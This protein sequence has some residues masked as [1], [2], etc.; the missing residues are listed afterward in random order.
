MQLQKSDIVRHRLVQ[1]AHDLGSRL[2]D[3]FMT[4]AF[5]ALSVIPTLKLTDMGLVDVEKFE[6]TSLFV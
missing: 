5:M 2:H 6:L 1:A 3:P 4:L